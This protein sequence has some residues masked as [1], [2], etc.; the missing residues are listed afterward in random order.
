MSHELALQSSSTALAAIAQPAFSVPVADLTEFAG[1]PEARRTEVTFTL[2]LLERIHALRGP[3]NFTKAVATI[4]AQNKHRMRG[5]SAPSLIRK[6]Y[7]Y[8][9]SVTAERSGGDWRVLVAGY[10]GPSSQPE[11]FVQEIRRV[12]ECN[13]RS[14]AEAL[15]QLRERW[16]AGEEIPGY[17]NWISHYEQLYPD[18]PL[19]KVWPRG[20]YPQGWSID[21]LR[22]YG[23]SKGARTLYQR[24]IAAAKKHFPSVIRDTSQLRPMERIVIDDFQLG[25]NCLFAGDGIHKPEIAPVAGLLAMCVGTRRKLHRGLGAMI[26]REE[27]QKDGSIKKVRS[28]IRRVDVQMLIHDILQKYGLPDYTITILCENATAS[29]APELKLAMETLFD[30]HVRV[31]TTGLIEHRTLTNGFMEHGGKPWEKGWV[32]STFNKLWNIL[33]ATKGYKGSNARLNGP[34]DM[35][36]KMRY[37][38]LLIGQGDGALN[39]PPEA[40]AQLR[41]PFLSVAELER[42]FDWA[43]ALCD[44]RTEHR[45]LGFERVTEFLLEEHGEPQPFSS[46]ALLSPEAQLQVQPVER[47]ESPVERWHR[48]AFNVTWTPIPASVLALLLLT[49]K[50]VEYRN[51]A[52]TFVHA[53]V[54]FSYTDPEG[55][56]LRRYQEGTEFLCYLDLN[57]PEN[58]HVATMTGAYVGTL[59]RLGG[60]RGMIDVRD[61][62]ALSAEA[63]RNREIVNR[64]LADLRTRHAGEEAQLLA[65]RQHN[66]AIVAAHKVATAGMTKAE[67]IGLAAGEA[68]QASFEAKEKAKAVA[69]ANRPTSMH[70]ASKGLSDLLHADDQ[71]APVAE[72]VTYAPPLDSSDDDADDRPAESGRTS[73]RDL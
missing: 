7:A 33:G 70:K 26:T 9:G 6:Y 1:H 41:T 20:F 29:I 42:A 66:D 51:N 69:K 16:A 19:P 15:Q 34:A 49:P 14:M 31:E 60:R 18:R 11:K 40:I 12:C 45:Y 37:T 22:R 65:D 5:C 28:G 43:L 30:G 59:Q 8:M 64:E 46:L 63:G 32:E 54:G 36:E 53:G 17:G 62:E 21:N 35:D 24:G 47:M 44:E 48:L 25:C 10:K 50:K 23:P 56:I 4:A 38:R 71:G 13:H 58:L 52:L 72:P 57:S 68:A 39:L 27:K 73:L 67:R 61:K 55:K 2:Q 3:G